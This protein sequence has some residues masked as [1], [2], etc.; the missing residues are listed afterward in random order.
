MKNEN[1]RERKFETD[2]CRGKWLVFV[3]KGIVIVIVSFG[4]LLA[5]VFGHTRGDDETCNIYMKCNHPLESDVN[6]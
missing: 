5:L 2:M 3:R 6:W 4:T 1:T